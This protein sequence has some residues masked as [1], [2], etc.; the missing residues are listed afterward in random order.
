LRNRQIKNFL[1][2]TLLSLG[3]P[4]VG[5][6]DEVRRTQRGNN[7]VYCQDNELSWFDWSLVE[8]HAEIFRFLKLLI[9]RRL[10]RDIEPDRRP[11]SLNAVL[12]QSVKAWHGVHLYQP[13]WSD[14]SHSIALG[15]ELKR[16]GF[17][18]HLILN[19]YT[20]P[21]DFQLPEL[22]QGQVWRRWIDTGQP[23]PEDIVPWQTAPPYTEPVYHMQPHSVAMLFVQQNGGPG[24]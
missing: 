15:V 22:A 19:A 10:R 13:D 2:I 3:V 4:M 5:M 8:Q 16:D 14:N 18:C 9:A 12:Q 6:G 17:L 11:M 20:E 21:L 1:A 7:N 23:M 24:K